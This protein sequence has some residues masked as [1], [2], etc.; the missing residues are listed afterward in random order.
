[1][2]TQYSAIVKLCDQDTSDMVIIK[3]IPGSDRKDLDTVLYGVIYP[4]VSD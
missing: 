2:E 4:N 3:L 1:M